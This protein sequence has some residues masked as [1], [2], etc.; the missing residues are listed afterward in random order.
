MTERLRAA[1]ARDVTWVL[2][3]NRD[4][5]ARLD[6]ATRQCVHPFYV[7]HPWSRRGDP[8]RPSAWA[9]AN[10]TLSLALKHQLAAWD[11]VRR[12]LPASLVLEDDA[13][14]PPNLWSRLAELEAPADADVFY[15]G[16]YSSRSHVGT[17]QSEPLVV[18]AT[19]VAGRTAVHRRTNGTTPLLLGTNAYILFARAAAALVAPVRAE[20][21]ITLTL[22]DAPTQCRTKTGTAGHAP[23]RALCTR[24]S[25]P[26][27]HQYGPSS[28]L[29]GQD[30]LGLEQ[31]THWDPAHHHHGGGGGGRADAFAAAARPRGGA[32]G[33]KG[34][35]GGAVGPG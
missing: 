3:A 34:R 26:P 17:L 12:R 8:L 9:M 31:K 1:Q 5:V 32:G 30:L 24:L 14:V 13:M 16:S 25:A 2:C 28:W 20:A 18:P 6:G 19:S 15:L 29:V 27:A 4:D 22:L 21:D 7:P 33:G 10:G 23:S 11:I 35:G